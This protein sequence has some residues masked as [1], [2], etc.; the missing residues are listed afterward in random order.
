VPGVAHVS[1]V[2]VDPSRWGQGIA[3]ALLGQAEEAMCA[4]GYHLGRLWTAEEGPA[5]HFYE[6][7]GWRHDGRRKWHDR[8]GLDIVG[9]EKRPMDG[10]A[11]HES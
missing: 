3:T 9:Y 6:R 2:F 10:Q 7:R 11:G 5:R 4:R 1:A 8:L